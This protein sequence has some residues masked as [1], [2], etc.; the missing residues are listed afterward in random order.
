M[1]CHHHR[2]TCIRGRR[3]PKA[4]SSP[5]KH[6]AAVDVTCTESSPESASLLLQH[7]VLWCLVGSRQAL[8]AS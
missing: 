8:C 2:R 1:C 4:A 7:M 5:K 3:R 6:T